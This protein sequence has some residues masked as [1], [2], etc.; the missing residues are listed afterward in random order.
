MW[1]EVFNL[2]GV[3]KSI[4]GDRWEF[5][6][7]SVDDSE[8]DLIIRNS[9]EICETKSKEFN[10]YEDVV[11]NIQNTMV[12]EQDQSENN[13][14]SFDGSNI[15]NFPVHEQDQSLS[16]TQ[17]FESCNIDEIICKID[18]LSI[19]DEKTVSNQIERDAEKSMNDD[20]NDSVSG[21]KN[22]TNVQKK[23]KKKKN[24]KKS[25]IVYKGILKSQ[26]IPKVNHKRKVK[27]GNVEE[28][29]FSQELSYSSIPNKGLYPLGLGIEIK[30]KN[31]T[32]TV[33][34]LFRCQQLNLLERA[35]VIGISIP[36]VSSS[37]TTSNG[38][39]G[40]SYLSPLLET[41][42]FDY[43]GYSNLLYQPHSEDERIAILMSNKIEWSRLTDSS[44]CKQNKEKDNN[45]SI[46]SDMNKEVRNIQ[47]SRTQ[48]G[49]ACKPTKVDKLSTGKMKSMLT[50]QNFCLN[51]DEVEKLSKSDLIS[52]VRDLLRNC[53]LCVNT[54]CECVQL[55]V[56]CSSHLCSC[57]R[58][59][60]AKVCGNSYGIDLFDAEVVKT[61]RL[62]VI[63]HVKNAPATITH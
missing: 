9:P 16:N 15:E 46:L 1:D 27:W 47:T 59:G 7:P 21:I 4:I 30:E 45:N 23:K 61:Y 8:K 3:R 17:S 41:R 38:N 43:K 13:I 49:C 32:I 6:F 20:D 22:E 42:Q 52:K 31:R 37:S 40:Q 53:P 5:F 34:E 39:N 12:H 35:K 54:C 56:S 14:Q 29:H 24:K 10:D 36:N 57:S 51:K 55:E 26:N 58:Q 19:I 50:E 11:D 18:D 33:D 63:E 60:A 48:F 28:I 2:A 25:S 44:N 62:S